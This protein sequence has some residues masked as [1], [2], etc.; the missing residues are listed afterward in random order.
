MCAVINRLIYIYIYKHTD[1]H[2]HIYIYKH[3][4]TH[5]DIYIY[6]Y[7]NTQTHTRI[8]IYIQIH[9]HTHA[10]IY[11]YIYIYKHT[12]THAYIYIYDTHIIGFHS[13]RGN[14]TYNLDV[15][16]N[17]TI[18]I[19][20]ISEK[21]DLDTYLGKCSSELPT[22][23]LTILILLLHKRLQVCTVYYGFSVFIL[24]E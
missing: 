17:P 2:T 10:Y 11:I 16:N 9:R 22:G 18:D 1:T 14:K 23:N 4:D 21:Y 20:E 5:T 8:Y 24:T 15:S 3:T 6:I 13:R 19:D 12:D 7:T